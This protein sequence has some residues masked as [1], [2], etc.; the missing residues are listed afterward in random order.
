MVVGRSTLARRGK[1]EEE[2]EGIQEILEEE[3]FWIVYR[4]RVVE[5]FVSKIF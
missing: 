4:F 5:K 3:N 1:E 2:E